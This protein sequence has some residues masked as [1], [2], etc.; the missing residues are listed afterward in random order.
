MA[1]QAAFEQVSGNQKPSA[2]NVNPKPHQLLSLEGK[3]GILKNV[4][5]VKLLNIV[6]I[7]GSV[8]S[9]W[10]LGR[11]GLAPDIAQSVL[12]AHVAVHSC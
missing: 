9:R 2:I 5:P 12:D 10:L 1:S 6:L 7:M 11:W 3:E 4:L 8:A